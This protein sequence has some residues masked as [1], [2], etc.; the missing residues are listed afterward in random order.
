[1][2][3]TQA[4]IS[5]TAFGTSS[6]GQPVSLYTLANKNGMTARISNYGGLVTSLTAPDR[7]GVIE[8]VVLGY[9]SLA[10]YEADSAYIG[11]LIGRYGNRVAAGR[12]ELNGEQFRLAPNNSP[13]HLHGGERGFD[14]VVW[15]AEPLAGSGG[16]GLL[17]TY[18]SADGEE[19][20]P[21][22]LSVQVRYRLTDDDRF[23]IEY[24]ARTDRA[25]PV[26][27]TSHGYFNLTGGL[28]RDILNHLLEIN[29]DQFI[30]T[31]GTQIPTGE[32]RPVAGTP[33]DF[34][35]ARVVGD[36][37]DADDAQ[38]KI[39]CG[40]DHHFVV[41]H[42]DD[43]ELVFMARLSDPQSGRVMEVHSTEPG[44]QL[45]TGNHLGGSRNH[46]GVCLETQHAPDSP[47]QPGFPSTILQPG[48]TYTSMT[49]YSFSA[50]G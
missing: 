12:F 29:A 43:G 2:P 30:P 42:A 47:N 3:E 44:L 6:Q 14:K 1:V 4:S 10:E 48:E 38:I 13:N 21:G 20:Y 37:I 15:S 46:Y 8:N 35:R 33:F 41:N 25:T 19:G 24:Q 22:T 23:A 50:A 16:P 45:Y 9:G 27:L 49:I 32:I 11:A 36:S 34:R 28:K 5:E 7:D 40:Y 26:N 39:G 17:L 31:D 18:V